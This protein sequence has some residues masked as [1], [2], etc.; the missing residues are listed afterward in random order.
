LAGIARLVCEKCGSY[1][2]LWASRNLAKQVTSDWQKYYQKK[3]P[4]QI[5]PSMVQRDYKRIIRTFGIPSPLPKVRGYSSGREKGTKLSPRLRYPTVKKTA[6][7]K[8]TA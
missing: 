2:N 4:N 8:K 3:M 5:T 7:K 6:S 1:V